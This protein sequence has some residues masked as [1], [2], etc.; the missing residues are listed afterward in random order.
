M[1]NIID[2]FTR[3]CL[4]IRI[5]RKL[6]STDVID[7][8]SDLFI[9]RGVPGH[10]RSDNGPESITKAG[11]GLDNRCRRQDRLHRARQSMGEWLLREL[12]LAPRIH[13]ELLKL[14]IDVGQGYCCNLQRQ[15]GVHAGT[16]CAF[17][18]LNEQAPV[19]VEVG[20]RRTGLSFSQGVT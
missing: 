17:Q 12:Q 1:L 8:L 4:A 15:H 14:G 3:E 6:N 11:A 18:K 19:H 9:L 2:E 5:S 16:S 20:A 7:V 13:G 10:V